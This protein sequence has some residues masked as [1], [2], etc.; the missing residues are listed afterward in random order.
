[1]TVPVLDDLK[2][3]Y[4]RAWWALILRGLLGLAVGIF[5][6]CRP[7]DSVAAFALLIAFWA[8]FTGIVDIVHAIELSSVMKHWWVVLLSGLVGVGFGV[9]ALYY[10]PGLSL[11]FVVVWVAWWLLLT[12]ILAIYG[13]VRLKAAGLQWGWPAA[14]GVLGVVA[15]VFALAS[16]PAT[17][18]AVMG[19]IAG[20]AIVSGIAL[21]IGAFKLRSAVKP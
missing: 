10:F 17:L 19:L 21:I 4:H 11:A 7:L 15:G 9:A 6:L 2:K 20:F 16:P 13:A 18:A 3:A 5:I 12:G 14:F 8:I 1:M